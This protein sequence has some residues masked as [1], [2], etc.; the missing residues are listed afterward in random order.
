MP[1]ILIGAPICARKP[2]YTS[3]V[4]KVVKPILYSP[5]VSDFSGSPVSLVIRMS[6]VYL[7]PSGLAGISPLSSFFSIV[8]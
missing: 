2:P 5:M 6:E 7:L 4:L 3:P 8:A 1:G